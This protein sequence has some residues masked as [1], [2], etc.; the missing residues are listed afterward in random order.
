MV[1]QLNSALFIRILSILSPVTLLLLWEFLAYI[2]IIDVRL[3]I[4]P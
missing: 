1:K 2:H 3:L 4:K